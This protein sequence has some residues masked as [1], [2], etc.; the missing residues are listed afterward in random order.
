MLQRVNSFTDSVTVSVQ[1]LRKV[2]N[3]LFL[4]LTH[5]F[6][7]ILAKILCIKCIKSPLINERHSHSADFCAFYRSRVLVRD[8][9]SYVY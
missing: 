6:C 2:N 9:N 4:V 7:L 8:D 1:V 3:N 5:Y